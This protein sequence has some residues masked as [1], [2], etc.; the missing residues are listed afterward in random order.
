MYTR[1]PW[2]S[3]RLDAAAVVR[4]GSTFEEGRGDV[5]HDVR[6]ELR[7]GHHTG[8]GAGGRLFNIVDPVEAWQLSDLETALAAFVA[9]RDYR[10]YYERHGA[11]AFVTL[12]GSRN[13]SLTGSY[14][15]ERWASRELRNPFTLFNG[16]RPWRANP[17]VDE[18]LFNIGDVSLRFDTRT[19]PE[20]PWSGWFLN[21]D[22][23]HGEGTVAEPAIQSV[24]HAGDEIAYNRGFLDLRRY[25]RLGPA[26]Q[27]N[28]RVVLGGWLSGDPLPVERRLS[29]D[30]PGV[31]P[32]FGFRD[33]MAGENVGTCNES[34]V[35]NAMGAMCD[36]IALAQIEYRG[37]LKL[38]FSGDWEDW[39]R[40][41]HS[42]HGDVTW[43]FFADAG[44]GWNAA[45]TSWTFP[46]L[47]T[48]RSD[49][50]LGLDIGGIGVYAAKAVSPSN[51]PVNFFIR[52]RHR[53]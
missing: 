21:A 2:G 17:T 11:N 13:L 46:A 44:R 15:Q 1:T 48:F 51:E 23:E 50:G 20:D 4:T 3:V 43:V 53:F 7:F 9:R 42:A 49:V 14:G 19:D 39:P 16:E 28:M 36:R 18:G 24:L 27:L 12:F 5:G 45:S 47:S 29:V 38:D 8:I 30:G 10:D 37:D 26:A 33:V 35:V 40:H 32:G 22:V 52:L 25:N 31:M 34:P 6:T 41:Y